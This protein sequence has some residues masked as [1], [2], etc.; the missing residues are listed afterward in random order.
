M[1]RLIKCFAV[2]VCLTLFSVV[3]QAQMIDINTATATELA[4]IKGIGPKKAEAIVKYRTEH[5]AFQSVD[6]LVKVP[7][8]KDK[9]LANIK[10]QVSVGGVTGTTGLP[11]AP[12]TAPSMTKPA[13]PAMP[14][15][16]SPTTK[17]AVPATKPQP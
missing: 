12:V 3:A 4:T 9:T 15:T 17:P 2:V 8:I 13:V 11:K 16:P 7:G 10:D 5:G 14:T 6:D 1:F